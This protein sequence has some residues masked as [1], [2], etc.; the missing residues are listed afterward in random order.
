MHQQVMHRWCHLTE[1]LTGKVGDLDD[2][3][4]SQNTQMNIN[5]KLTLKCR[6]TSVAEVM[7][8]RW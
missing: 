6:K 1:T 5:T 4:N 7:A 2:C 8:F 3:I